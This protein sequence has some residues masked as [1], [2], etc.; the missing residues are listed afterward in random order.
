[1]KSFEKSCRS[2]DLPPRRISVAF[3]FARE[4][5]ARLDKLQRVTGARSRAELVQRSL[6]ILCLLVDAHGRGERSSLKNKDGS[7]DQLSVF[8]VQYKRFEDDDS[9]AVFDI[10]LPHLESL[11]TTPN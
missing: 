5:I 4:S 3:D 2:S 1:M 11:A 6:S 10:H 8:L 9:Y 7:M